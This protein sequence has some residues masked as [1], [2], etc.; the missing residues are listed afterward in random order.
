MV[1]SIWDWGGCTASKTEILTS[2]IL[3]GEGGKRERSSLIS[4][5]VGMAFS[6][7]TSPSNTKRELCGEGVVSGPPSPPICSMRGLGSLLDLRALMSWVLSPNVTVLWSDD[8]EEYVMAG[9][10]RRGD[11]GGAGW[12]IAGEKV[13]LA[14][15][16]G[17]LTLDAEQ[18]I[19]MAG[20]GG[21]NNGGVELPL[22]D[23]G[24][25]PMELVSSAVDL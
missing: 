13:L 4:L 21:T 5:G 1:L 12:A 25:D 7:R 10:C 14:E 19:T 9:R 17:D 18:S 2:S 24:L 20:G 11:E 23:I 22:A 16:S 15:G 8:Q 6:W 3:G